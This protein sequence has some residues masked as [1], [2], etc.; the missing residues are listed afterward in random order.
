MS[1]TITADKT[2][3]DSRVFRDALG[4]FATGV[5]I[6]TTTDGDNAPVGMTVS[7]FNSVSMDPPL[8]L[9]SVT[10]AAHSAETFRDTKTFAVHVL[11]A[12]QSAL[13]NRFAKSGADKF[14]GL[15]YSLCANGNPVLDGA[16][17]RFDCETW[18][19]YEGGD[20]WI[21]VGRVV[22]LKTSAED[23]LV[24]RAGAYATATPLAQSNPAAQNTGSEG[25]SGGTIDNLLLYHLSRAYHQMSEQ[26]HHAV[27][28][29]GLSLPEW[30]LLASLHGHSGRTTQELAARVFISQVK[31]REL[32]QKLSEEGLC[33]INL[34]GER[35][36]VNSTPE[37]EER[38]AHLFQ[39]SAQQEEAALAGL[40][41]SQVSQ[42]LTA[43]NNI[44]ENT[45]G[46][47]GD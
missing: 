30:R 23:G 47:T 22:D 14:S 43:L 28:D 20:H 11:A 38:V 16:A 18:A 31:A 19:V 17:A 4:S 36:M 40:S 10:K 46:L 7:S 12:E 6:I 41:S 45:D 42:L 25:D 32:S 33:E 2:A 15:D 39:L 5:T 13:S 21:I 27:T 9:W 1:N 8:I 29:S 44:V 37:G 3:F 26:F 24:F 35:M 34:N